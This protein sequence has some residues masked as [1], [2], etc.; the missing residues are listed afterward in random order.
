ML[1]FKTIIE[2]VTSFFQKEDALEQPS[3]AAKD[4][5]VELYEKPLPHKPGERPAIVSHHLERDGKLPTT[6]TFSSSAPQ[7]AASAPNTG[8]ASAASPS[9]LPFSSAQLKERLKALDEPRQEPVVIPARA[10]LERRKPA[11]HD[12]EIA[13]QIAQFERAISTVH[14]EMPGSD[15]R[16]APRDQSELGV[17][18]AEPL[19][20]PGFF[21]GLA[22][23]L[24]ERGYAVDE[25]DLNA[26][27]ERM[28]AH[29]AQRK[30]SEERESRARSYEEALSRKIA[31]LQELERDWVS[32]QDE[33]GAARGRVEALEAE[34]AEKTLELKGIVSSIRAHA[35][36]VSSMDASNQS[37]A[38]ASRQ[39]PQETPRQET[40]RQE[41]S[42]QE[43]SRQESSPAAYGPHTYSDSLKSFVPETSAQTSSPSTTSMSGATTNITPIITPNIARENVT[44][45]EN[46]TAAALA[47]RRAPPGQE[48]VLKDGGKVVTLEELRA[49]LL[50]M[51]EAVFHHHVTPQ[52]ND[53]ATWMEGSFKLPSVA[54]RARHVR[55][56]YELALLLSTGA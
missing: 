49:A 15:A 46:V 7:S 2:N 42:R 13:L 35:T 22:R 50:V 44:T 51:D 32:K 8:T 27:L 54:E 37:G 52:R 48:F 38:S 45:A 3:R 18:R 6:S 5:A 56:K 1:V 31:E 19:S 4:A 11:L 47:A 40:S 34:I 25:D 39:D 14:H 43:S 10:P 53:F 20:R 33:I 12:D 30:E 21:D 9:K 29:H 17:Q 24:R 26:A 41:S 36:F 23:F 28:K 16:D 55:S